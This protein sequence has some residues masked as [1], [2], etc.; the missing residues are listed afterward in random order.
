MKLN[1][2]LF[3][4]ATLIATAVSA[5]ANQINISSLVNSD[6]TAYSGGFNY[7]QN[8]GP[9]TVAGVTFQLATLAANN[10]TAVIQ[11]STSGGISQTYTIPVGLFG[12]TTV[13]TLINS[14]F[15]SLNTDIGSLVF[16]G[17]GGEPTH[18]P[19]PRART[20]ATI[21]PTVSSILQPG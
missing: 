15:G 17:A 20:Y 4:T 1:S 16:H 10:H 7:P 12:I 14:A 2:V 21:S 9:L 11:G 13:D 19:S 6:L 5:H 3:G 8:G 18:I